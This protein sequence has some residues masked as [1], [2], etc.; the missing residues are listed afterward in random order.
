[1]T[2][3]ISPKVITSLH[4]RKTPFRGAGHIYVAYFLPKISALTKLHEAPTELRAVPTKDCLAPT[5]LK[6]TA[7]NKH[8]V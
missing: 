1:M 7:Q 5:E 2:T 6:M 3:V 8:C 4:R